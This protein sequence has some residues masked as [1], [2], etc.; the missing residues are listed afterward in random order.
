MAGK[1]ESLELP[2]DDESGFVPAVFARSLDEAERFR[3]LL[4]DHDIPA[5]VATDDELAESEDVETRTGRL[6]GM[7]RGV[8]VLVPEALLDEASRVIADFEDAEGFQV[9]AD[10]FDDDDDDEEDEFGLEEE[11][12]DENLAESD[13]EKDDAFEEAGDQ[14]SFD[15]ED[16]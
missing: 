9:A 8:A 12:E 11:D 4:D 6:A 16:I 15:S 3:E 13:D 5:V 10:E 7:T 1:N 2:E 14:D